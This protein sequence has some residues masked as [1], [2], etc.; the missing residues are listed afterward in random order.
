MFNLAFDDSPAK[1]TLMGDG[2]RDLAIVVVAAVMSSI[3]E[4]LSWTVDFFA[5]KK[6]FG[7]IIY[8]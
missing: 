8:L 2:Q 3:G 1:T 5:F 6:K 7:G 4:T